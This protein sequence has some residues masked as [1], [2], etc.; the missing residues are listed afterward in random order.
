MTYDTL[1]DRAT[2]LL[3]LAADIREELER[4]EARL[5]QLTPPQGNTSQRT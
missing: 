1:R 5:G 2:T 3:A 4:I